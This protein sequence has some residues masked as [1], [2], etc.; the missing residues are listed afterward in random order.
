MEVEHVMDSVSPEDSSLLTS[1]GIF[2][3]SSGL[4]GFTTRV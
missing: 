1:N 2:M 3:A 4:F